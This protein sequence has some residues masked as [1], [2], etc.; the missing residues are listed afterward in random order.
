VN[1]ADAS[2]VSWTKGPGQYWIRLT[3]PEGTDEVT[4]GYLDCRLAGPPDGKCPRFSGK[5]SA[6]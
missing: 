2:F 6:P 1:T 3:H 4:L 5:N